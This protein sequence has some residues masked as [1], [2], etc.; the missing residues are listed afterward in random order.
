[1]SSKGQED[2]DPNNA[3]LYGEDE[4]EEI[5]EEEKQQEQEVLKQKTPMQIPHA[6]TK[7]KKR[8]RPLQV[9]L[10]C[11]TFLYLI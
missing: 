2:S 9:N 6:T 7:K 1:M 3:E 5:E 4:G 11:L 10:T 8:K